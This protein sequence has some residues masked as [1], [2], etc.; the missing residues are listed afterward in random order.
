MILN[1]FH[2]GGH[3]TN[4]PVRTD[5]NHTVSRFHRAA[6]KLLWLGS[7]MSAALSQAPA[8]VQ[9][10]E[11]Q[12]YQAIDAHANYPA[13]LKPTPELIQQLKVPMGFHI[14]K[15][16]E[17]LEAPRILA[18]APLAMRSCSSHSTMASPPQ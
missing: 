13:K 14:A 2:E 10:L 3:S 5:T 1:P 7:V 9:V 6:I 18:V 16:A 17:N 8:Q 4:L 15:F 12:V 11:Q